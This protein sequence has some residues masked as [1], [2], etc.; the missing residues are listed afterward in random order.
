MLGTSNWDSGLEG[1]RTI[2]EVLRRQNMSHWL[3]VRGDVEHDWTLWL[4]R[5]RHYVSMI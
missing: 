2:C 5:F 4:E 1:N 3:E